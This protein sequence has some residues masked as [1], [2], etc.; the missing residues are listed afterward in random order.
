[1]VPT[2]LTLLPA[3]NGEVDLSWTYAGDPAVFQIQRST[4]GDTWLDIQSVTT[5]SAQDFSLNADTTYWYLGYCVQYYC[6]YYSS[7]GKVWR[8]L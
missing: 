3:V 8:K 5:T 6:V 4:D 7:V 1:M 2:D